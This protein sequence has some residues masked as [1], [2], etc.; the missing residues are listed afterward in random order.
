MIELFYL[1]STL[2]LGLFAGSLLTEATIL[3]PHWRRM[4]AEEFFRLHKSLGPNLF[5]YFAPL[6]TA[7]VSLAVVT[8]VIDGAQNIAWLASAGL[9]LVALGIFFIYFRTAN[10]R[11]AEHSISKE[12][13]GSELKRW[14]GWHWLRTALAIL[15]LA[16]SIYGHT[17]GLD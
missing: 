15:A 5:R 3:V 16:A 9:S 11:F 10:N 8:A 12:E 1:L 6:T 17:L 14:A 4:D 2:T 13:L 7:A